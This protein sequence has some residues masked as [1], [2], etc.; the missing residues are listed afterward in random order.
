[1]AVHLNLCVLSGM[2]ACACLCRVVHV[3]TCVCMY[4]EA[5][6]QSLFSESYFRR[7]GLSPRTLDWLATSRELPVS[8]CL[9]WDYTA[10]LPHP[11]WILGLEL[12]SSR[13]NGKCFTDSHLFISHLQAVLIPGL[14]T[15]ILWLGTAFI[16]ILQVWKVVHLWTPSTVLL[17]QH[18]VGSLTKWDSLKRIKNGDK[19]AWL[20][21]SP[22]DAYS[23]CTHPL[24]EQ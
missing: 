6:S 17:T 21:H 24:T 9:L 8:T 2:C 1:M 7:H 20:I 16:T 4:T 13:L 18:F 15:N 10:T 23:K 19:Q 5:R 14:Y 12:K 3:C 22:Q 11:P